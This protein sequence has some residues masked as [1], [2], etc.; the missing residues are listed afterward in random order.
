MTRN[1]EHPKANRDL[2]PLHRWFPKFS[3]VPHN[4]RRPVAVSFRR[5]TR[6]DGQTFEGSPNQPEG[7]SEEDP[8]P[9]SPIPSHLDSILP[10]NRPHFF[11]TP[12]PSGVS[13]SPNRSAMAAAS[14]DQREA[15]ERQLFSRMEQSA[16]DQFAAIRLGLELAIRLHGTPLRI[17]LCVACVSSRG[18]L[19]C[20]QCV[21]SLILVS[22]P[23]CAGIR[24]GDESRV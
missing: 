10:G 19:R 24:F 5:F 14:D 6:H 23:P 17:F 8:S 15:A 7:T 13:G 16:A 4:S 3:W 20:L 12:K 1:W 2:P 11:V 18:T 21:S 9:N 22:V